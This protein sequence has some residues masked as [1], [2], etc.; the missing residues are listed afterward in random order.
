M[1]DTFTL[2]ERDTFQSTSD[3]TVAQQFLDR[4]MPV[5]LMDGGATKLFRAAIAGNVPMIDFL[6]SAG[7]NVNRMASGP[8]RIF[9]AGAPLNVA[10]ISGKPAAVTRLLDH[11]ANPRIYNTYRQ[12]AGHLLLKRGTIDPGAGPEYKRKTINRMLDAGLPINQ[13]DNQGNTVLHVAVEHG[14]PMTVIED[15]LLRGA[16][17][18]LWN[19]DSNTPIHIACKQ[20]CTDA[21]RTL[22]RCGV[23]IQTPNA[24]GASTLHIFTSP[25]AA[26]YLVSEGAELEA[27]DDMGRTPLAARLLQCKRDEI[28]ADVE[29]LIA[30][31][32]NLDAPDFTGRTPRD[33]IVQQKLAVVSALAAALAA[34][35]AMR[36]AGGSP[37]ASP[38]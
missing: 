30:A 2:A 13:V 35:Q 8:G 5:D 10:I 36:A 9:G 3:I 33:I 29:R 17:A 27:R 11:G 6:V 38:G 32:A 18:S 20:S 21:L 23:S 24:R 1:A 4:G 31:G 12:T 15:L 22:I 16:D 19:T 34:R 25:D 14:A 37:S 7:A 26:E 28:T